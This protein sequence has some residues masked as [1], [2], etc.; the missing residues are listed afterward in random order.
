MP[1]TG[2]FVGQPL[3]V[4]F[5]KAQA[6][7]N[8]SDFGFN[9]VAIARAELVLQTVIPIR[10]FGVLRAGVVEFRDAMSEGF[11]LPLHGVEFGEHRHAFGKHSAPGKCKSILRQISGSG[12]FGNNQGAVVERIQAGKDLHQRG[13]AGTIRAH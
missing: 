13:L 12:S 11:E 10:N 4:F 8:A 9:R 5:A 1:S 6:H 7:K 2:K 3:P